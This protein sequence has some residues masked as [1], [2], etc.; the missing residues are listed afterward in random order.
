MALLCDSSAAENGVEGV[1]G[2]M[3]TVGRVRKVIRL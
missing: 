3:K 1:V 2:W